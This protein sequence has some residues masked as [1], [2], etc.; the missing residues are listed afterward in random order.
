MTLKTLKKLET[1]HNSKGVLIYAFNTN[2]DY[3]SAATFAAKQVKKHLNLPVTVITD[4]EI[5]SEHFDVIVLKSAETSSRIYRSHTG[6]L[7][8]VEWR[9]KNRVTAYDLSPYDKTLL[10][11]ADFFMYNSSL[12]SIFETD[13]EFACYDKITDVTGSEAS[14]VR[15]GVTAPPMLWATVV[16]FKKSH[17]AESIF[18]FMNVIKENWDYYSLLYRFRSGSYRND[19][20]LSIAAQTLSGFTTKITTLP[21]TL[22]T[23]FSNVEVVKVTGDEVVYMWDNTNASKIVGTNIHCMNK[24]SLD[25]FYE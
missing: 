11:D 24:L 10:I 17:M 25:K 22:H 21:G 20:S 9:N 2:F 23:M 4:T 6:E 18:S 8:E 14:T 19:F 12:R 1:G 16:Y 3:V 5:E 15:L 13:V 7:L